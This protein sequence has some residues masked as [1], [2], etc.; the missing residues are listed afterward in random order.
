MGLQRKKVT[1]RTKK[2][3]VYQRSMLVKG[4]AR[5]S[6]NRRGKLN[7]LNPWQQHHTEHVKGDFPKSQ[8]SSGPGSDHSWFALSVAAMKQQH[9]SY[10]D[11]RGGHDSTW[12]ALSRDHAEHRQQRA[13][14]VVHAVEARTGS[15][16]P[17]SQ[18][19]RSYVATAHGAAPIPG[20]LSG[21]NRAEQRR[22]HLSQAFGV[23]QSDIEIKT[24]R[25]GWGHGSGDGQ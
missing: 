21:H 20:M 8:G 2:G 13:L 25:S 9:A 7:A 22:V 15:P 19:I 11:T 16:E 12:D 6:L 5:K 14:S 3:K 23:G 1:V 10:R 18:H 17:G 4:A 24:P